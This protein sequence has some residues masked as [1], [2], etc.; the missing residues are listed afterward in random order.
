MQLRDYQHQALA[1]AW[2]RF[3]AGDRATLV[4][5]PTGTGKTVTFAAHARRTVERGGRCLVLAHRTELL[6][7]AVAKLAASG[8]VAELEQAGRRAGLAACVVVASVQTLRGK[9][10]ERWPRDAFDDI[11]V[12]E[13]HHLPAAGYRAIVDWFATAR[14]LGVTATPD[15]LDGKGLGEVFQSCAFR[16]ELRAAI[17]DGWLVPVIARRVRLESVD[18]SAV[19]TRAGDFAQDQL[20][21]VMGDDEALRGAARA[22]LG[23]AGRRRTIAFCVDVAHA[24][25]LAAALNHDE[26]GCAAAVD[27]TM[28]RAERAAI[29]DGFRAGRVRIVTNCEILTEGFDEVGVGC[30][31]LVRPTKSRALYAQM[32][33]RGVRPIEPPVAAT[34]ETRRAAIAASAKPDVLLLDVAG[35]TGRH[36]LVGP[37]DVLAGADALDPEVL[38]ELE[39][40]LG[41]DPDRSASDALDEAEATVARRQ[42][43][44]AET[45]VPRYLAEEV[46]PFLG[47][48]PQ[49]EMDAAWHREPAT[50]QQLDDL[51]KA[52]FSKLPEQLS[53]ADATRI[54]ILLR[55]RRD[56]GLVSLKQ[57]RMI[58][59]AG[60][61]PRQM[62]AHVAAQAFARLHGPGGWAG[63]RAVVRDYQYSTLN[64]RSA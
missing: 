53:K 22:I 45:A 47:P 40:L 10:L 41:L 7:Q 27:G 8:V 11:V 61:D 56:L 42:L 12:D 20:G 37:A 31:A 34:A 63:F 51:E 58:R 33:G 38:A 48:L 55:Q 14:V 16:Y 35:V 24:H 60:A 26:P 25:G 43:E 2:E 46:D 1:A 52:G 57:A 6:E 28:G 4:V 19:K 5:S 44:L 3:D 49:V 64:R 54:L 32:A 9:R 30:I 59:N 17:R 36:R 21:A 29:L 13:A 62:P 39:R 50:R 15:R 18:L 23:E